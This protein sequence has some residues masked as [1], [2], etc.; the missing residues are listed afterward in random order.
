MRRLAAIVIVIA[1]LG[2]WAG[3]S[4]PIPTNPTKR[5][6]ITED[7]LAAAREDLLKTNDLPMC[8]NAVQ[9]LN[10][11]L[12]QQHKG[13]RPELTAELRSLLEKRFRLNKDELD[14]VTSA[15]L[16]Q[17]D[18]HYLESCLLFADAA[19]AIIEEG[20]TP[21]QRAETAFAWVVRQ[22]RLIEHPGPPV[23]AHLALRR[24]WGSALDRSLVFFS[25]LQQL[26]LDGCIVALPGPSQGQVR[27]W[28]CG[29][30]LLQEKQPELYLFDPRLGLP[31]PGAKGQGPA[32][33][34]EVKNQPDLLKQL[35]A[36]KLEYDVSPEQLRSVELHVAAPLSAMAPRFQVLDELLGPSLRVK[37]SREPGT[38]LGNFEKVAAVFPEGSRP[39]VHV[40]TAALTALRDYLPPQ[41]GGTGKTWQPLVLIPPEAWSKILEVGGEPERIMRVHAYQTFHNFALESRLPRNPFLRGLFYY[42]GKPPGADQMAR[43][44][45]R[46]SES[47]SE[48]GSPSG[49][50]RDI[51][52]GS[53][54]EE[55]ARKATSSQ[56]S[57]ESLERARMPRDLLLHG[58]WDEA[59]RI[60]VPMEEQLL[61]KRDRLNRSPDLQKKLLDWRDRMITAQANLLRA[62]RGELP[63]AAARQQAD[64]VWGE[65]QGP[66]LILLEG[67]AS[68]P[69][70]EEITFQIALCKHEAAERLQA[71]LAI[72]R[73]AGDPV[74]AQLAEDVRHAWRDAAHWWSRFLSNYPERR[75][76]AAREAAGRWAVSLPEY[77]PVPYT[78]AAQRMRAR[79]HEALGEREQ[80]SAL[81]AQPV[82]SA[83][84]LENLAR[85][86]EVRR[87]NESAGK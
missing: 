78:A 4:R 20:M 22:V 25:L 87:L 42:P 48:D 39:P 72:A 57:L 10:Q 69:L 36:D 41:E 19:R 21:L 49:G 34:T 18:A 47:G 77:P 31:L 74:P 53:V 32:T 43:P 65:G 45:D 76:A 84:P 60:L 12:N 66:C 83:G 73:K 86:L 44:F 68:Y 51:A 50:G 70:L 54:A 63:L 40:V 33:L 2:A 35:R 58:R 15:N 26:G 30:L 52:R 79:A 61:G 13:N 8:R 29:A 82:K 46:S 3:C 6:G 17:L 16:T 75:N 7:F 11:Y 1:A 81:L 59:T 56:G 64:L 55:V 80:A 38:L 5:Q 71:R 62:E 24:G 67:L 85:A 14:E 28:L 37:F 9:Q 27:I 23:P